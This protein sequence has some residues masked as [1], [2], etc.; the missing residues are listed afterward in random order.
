MR[1]MVKHRTLARGSAMP[2]EMEGHGWELQVKRL[3][4]QRGPDI[5][6]DLW[7]VPGVHRRR[8]GP[9]LIRSY[10]RVWWSGR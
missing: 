8:A 3:G 1:R 4:L 7:R 6:K 9:C 2:F 5:G 10:L